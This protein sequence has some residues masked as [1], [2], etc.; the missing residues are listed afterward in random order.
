ML[1]KCTKFNILVL[2]YQLQGNKT[3]NILRCGLNG[4]K[5]KKKRCGL[6]LD[7]I[8]WD[9]LLIH[10]SRKTV[11]QELHVLSFHG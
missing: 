3:A 7:V 5:K 2:N 6:N 10:I 4:K 11:R 9:S 1:G 8:I